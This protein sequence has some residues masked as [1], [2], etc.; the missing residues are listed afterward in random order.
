MTSCQACLDLVA[1][2]KATIE[3]AENIRAEAQ[4]VISQVQP[5]VQ[6][7]TRLVSDALAKAKD[8]KERIAKRL[9]TAKRTEMRA[10]LF[11]KYD[12]D[13]DGRWNRKE[14]AA[15]AKG[16][17]N[18]DMPEENLDRILRQ[19]CGGEGASIDCLQILK[20]SVGIARD[21]DKGKV[22]RAE[23]L[24]RERIE[25][26]ERERREAELQGR[27]EEVSGDIKARSLVEDE[28]LD[29]VFPGPPLAEKDKEA[30]EI[31]KEDFMRV[32]RIFYKVVKEIVL[33]DNL[34]IEQSDQLRRMDVGEIIEVFQGPMLDPS[35]G[36]YRIHGKALK[37]GIVGWATVAGN[38]GITFLMP[39]N[40][41]TSR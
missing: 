19:V 13:G 6:A 25:R 22:K 34:L 17:F 30:V 40:N 41:L 29:K 21:E 1:E 8:N 32:V 20:V 7:A 28:K 27:V 26:E 12:E 14:I 15:Y 10:K 38:Q 9:A 35:V 3:E 33:S 11:A 4:Q 2:K 31:S 36:V 24:E 16:E 23:R 18:F 5:R 37:D 39:D